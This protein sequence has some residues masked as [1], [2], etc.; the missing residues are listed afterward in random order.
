METAVLFPGTNG[1]VT[2]FGTLASV[3]GG[4]LI[5]V[6]FAATSYATTDASKYVLS[7]TVC[8]SPNVVTG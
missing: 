7:V 3:C 5:G 1:G 6:T 2:L 8:R 4:S